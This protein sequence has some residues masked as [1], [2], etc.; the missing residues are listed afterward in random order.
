MAGIWRE[1]EL[2]YRGRSHGHVETEYEAWSKAS[3]EKSAEAIVPRL[4]PIWE[5]AEL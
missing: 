2:S 1:S 5:R 3:R 4:R